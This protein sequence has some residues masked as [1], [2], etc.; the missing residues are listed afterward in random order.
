MTFDIYFDD[1]G[2]HAQASTAVA[3]CWVSTVEMW[4][5]FESRWNAICAE[6][7]LGTFHM[8]D[9][10]SSAGKFSQ[11]PENEKIRV[12]D[13]VCDAIDG[14]VY[15][16]F[17]YG[18]IKKE[19]DE[20]VSADWKKAHFGEK[21]YTFALRSCIGR[22]NEWRRR[23]YPRVPSRYVFDSMGKGKQE[24]ISVMNDAVKKRGDLQGFS[25]ESSA[26]RIPLQAADTFAW[27]AFQVLQFGVSKRPLSKVAKHLTD[28]IGGFTAYHRLTVSESREGFARWVELEKEAFLK[29]SGAREL[30]GMEMA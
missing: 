16:G 22:L 15:A 10:A 2:T 5:S 4:K 21:H 30:R 9:F 11:W 17:A 24:I 1:S 23:F 7:N 27:A 12:I 25:F 3:A 13:R 8:T 19:Y 20:L 18:V 26:A 6:E 28:R 29:S 14:S